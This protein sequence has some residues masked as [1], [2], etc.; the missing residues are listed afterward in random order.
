M[1]NI[2][3]ANPNGPVHITVQPG[4]VVLPL[5]D[6]GKG[7][8]HAAG[9]GVYS[10]HLV[11]DRVGSYTLTFP[12]GDTCLANVIPAYTYSVVPFKRRT[13]VGTNLNLCDDCTAAIAPPFVINLGGVSFSSVYVDSNGK[14]NF[15]FPENDYLNVSLPN[16]AEA[17]SF[18][19][20]AFWDDLLPI[21]NTNQNVFWA[22]VGTAPQRELVI[23]WRHVSRASGCTDAAAT[24]DFEVVFF[25]G[26]NNVLFNY[27]H[28]TFG[29]PPDC[30]LGDHGAHATAGIQL[31][32]P[33]AA[34][35]SYD[36]PNLTDNLS[37]QFTLA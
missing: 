7:S 28:T 4:N 23:E 35:Y 11:A 2:K 29:R 18:L 27:A 15:L 37:L 3:C 16:T 20:A 30:A 22:V 19:V 31:T 34:H 21:Q 9:D 8:D 5:L 13:I 33:S 26:S 12:G 36:Q 6:D 17:Y 1:L 25:E 10:G 24:V 32:Y 14:V